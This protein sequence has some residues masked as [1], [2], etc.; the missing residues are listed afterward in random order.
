VNGSRHLQMKVHFDKSYK[1]M[2][3]EHCKM[4]ALYH[5]MLQY[6]LDSRSSFCK[7]GYVTQRTNFNFNLNFKCYS[8]LSENCGP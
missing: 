4:I 7:V 2:L 3:R 8:D 5:R 1:V 6:A